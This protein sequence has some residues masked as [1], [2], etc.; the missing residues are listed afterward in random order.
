LLDSVYIDKNYRG[1][2]ISKVI[3]NNVE[4]QAK[5]LGIKELYLYTDIVGLYEKY[6]WVFIKEVDAP[7]NGAPRTQRLYKIDLK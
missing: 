7:V 4:N 3:M 1:L 5:Q 2:G 6:D